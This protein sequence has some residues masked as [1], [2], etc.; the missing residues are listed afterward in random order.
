[1]PNANTP[2]NSDN[3]NN[4]VPGGKLNHIIENV[5]IDFLKEEFWDSAEAIFQEWEQWKGTFI[6]RLS[7]SKPEVENILVWGC[8]NRDRITEGVM[9]ENIKKIFEFIEDE[10]QRDPVQEEITREENKVRA[11]IFERNESVRGRLTDINDKATYFSNYM[12]HIHTETWMKPKE[13]VELFLTDFLPEFGQERLIQLISQG[14]HEQI[15]LEIYDFITSKERIDR[16]KN[17]TIDVLSKNIEVFWFIAWYLLEDKMV[18]DD[19]GEGGSIIH[20]IEVSIQK[21]LWY[22]LRIYQLNLDSYEKSLEEAR[23]KR[24]NLNVNQIQN[25]KSI[26]RY[27]TRIATTKVA[28]REIHELIREENTTEEF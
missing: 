13:M 24:W 9:P 25:T 4:F 26:K 7:H 1:M 28:M 3:G 23:S 10:S 14:D 16:R 11:I 19:N 5:S 17:S 15:C 21:A 2:S 20:T 18:A 12:K 27:E 8:L 6:E 22:K